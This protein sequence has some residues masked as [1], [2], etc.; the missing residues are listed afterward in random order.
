VRLW[1]K[2]GLRNG[3][4]CRGGSILG[5]RIQIYMS[6]VVIGIGDDVIGIDNDVI[7]S[8]LCTRAHVGEVPM[9]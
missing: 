3:N 5:Q 1:S 9:T 8:L 4:A 7:L 6:V 2:T